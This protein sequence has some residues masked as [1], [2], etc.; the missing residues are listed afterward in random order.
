MDNKAMG[1]CKKRTLSG[2]RSTSP[3]FMT[4]ETAVNNVFRMFNENKKKIDLKNAMNTIS[5]FGI[6][7]EELSEAGLSYE[8]LKALGSA[9]S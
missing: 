1:K 3:Y 8:N 5:L 9:I 4:R 2:R 6:S 7:A